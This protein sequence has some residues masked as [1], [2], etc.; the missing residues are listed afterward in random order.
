[1]KPLWMMNVWGGGV[2]PSAVLVL[3]LAVMVTIDWGE[4]GRCQ[5]CASVYEWRLR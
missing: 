4:L 5:D 2:R 1:M 3:A